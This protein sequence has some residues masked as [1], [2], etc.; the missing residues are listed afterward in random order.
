MALIQPESGDPG[1]DRAVAGAVGADAAELERKLLSDGRQVIAYGSL[2]CP[3]CELPLPGRPA[4]AAGTV[5]HC[6]WCGHTAR[7]RELF[8]PNVLDAPANGVALIAR[9]APTGS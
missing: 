1:E 5:L 2:I 4:V 7:A 3:E 9:L 6:G 8:R